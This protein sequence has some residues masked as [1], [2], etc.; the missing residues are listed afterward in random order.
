MTR[1]NSDPTPRSWQQLLAAYADGEL[2]TAASEQVR[3][4][5]DEHPHAHTRLEEQW[6]LSPGNVPF[7]DMVSPPNPDAVTWARVWNR[8]ETGLDVPATPAARPR[9]RG[10]WWRR[11]LAVAILALPGAA[12]AAAVVAACIPDGPSPVAIAPADDSTGDEVFQFA[13]AGDVEILSI[14][15]VDVPQLVVGE[16]P[17]NNSMT[18]AAAGDVRL[19]AMAP[20]N[21]GMVPEVRMGGIDAPVIHAPL[22]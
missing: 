9:V 5:L 17:F 6:S 13:A 22:R 3:N 19:E 12:A 10:P 21:D 1:P 14:R 4:W 20:A 8:I 18:L 15:D 11:G 2:D 7:W 16:P